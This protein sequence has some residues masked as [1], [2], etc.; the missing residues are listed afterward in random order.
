MFDSVRSPDGGLDAACDSDVLS[1]SPT[2][3]AKKH[4]MMMTPEEKLEYF[5]HRARTHE[6]NQEVGNTLHLVWTKS[7][8]KIGAGAEAKR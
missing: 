1:V 7:D 2:G 4:F 3:S 8:F 5:D 6:D